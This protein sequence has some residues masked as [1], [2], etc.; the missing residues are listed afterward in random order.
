MMQMHDGQVGLGSPHNHPHQPVRHSYPLAITDAGF[1]TALN[2]MV[3]TLPYALVRFG[4]LF[5]AT[6]ATLIWYGITFG[7]GAFIGSRVP[8][9]GWVWIIGG[10]G[11]WGYLWWFVVRYF[12]YLLKAGQIA[13]LTELITYGQVQNGQEGMFQYGTRVVKQRFGEV[14][15]MF[16]LDALVK[17]VVRA[18]NRTLNWIANLLPIPGLSGITQIANSIV[19]AA[20]TYI[21]E[22]L[23]SYSL[24]R[25]DENQWRSAKDGLIYYA[26]NAQEV[27]KTGVWIV[28]LDYVLSFV[29]WI[30]CLVPA[31]I[32]AWMLPVAGVGQFFVVLMAVLAAANV[33][34]AFLHPLFLIM[35]MIKFHVSVRNQP[36]NLEWDDRLSGV[37]RKFGEL[38]QK[39]SESMAELPVA[40]PAQSPA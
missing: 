25:G 35:M 21:D 26:Q 39:A 28:V 13:V 11:T 12:L 15:A 7:G 19:F 8:V 24:A 29:T 10:L 18:F 34:S 9:L 22:T 6:V 2:L 4:V 23:F 1:G 20:T 17:G 38:K 40:S 33:R 5:A 30:V 31:G 14:N 3:Q 36:I 37:S 16:A 27:L 32:I